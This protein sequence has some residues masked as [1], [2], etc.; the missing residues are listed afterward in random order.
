MLDDASGGIFRLKADFHSGAV[1]RVGH[2]VPVVIDHL[3]EINDNG[4]H[5]VV[6]ALLHVLIVDPESAGC[7][8]QGF[9]IE[10]HDRGWSAGNC[11]ESG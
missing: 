4:V 2:G 5:V 9:D 3:I 7:R 6:G 8:P 10:I 11:P 1:R